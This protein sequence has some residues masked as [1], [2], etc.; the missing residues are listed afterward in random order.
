[1]N[2]ITTVPL[3][4]EPQAAQLVKELG[5]QAELDQMLERARQIIPGLRR[6]HVLFAPPYDTGP[7][8]SV[9]IEAYRD[10]AAQEPDDLHWDLYSKWQSATI[11]PDVYRHLTLLIVDEINHVR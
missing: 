5:M 3:A 2:T 7:D 11:S 10:A 9:V 4:I 6:L 8:P 1:M